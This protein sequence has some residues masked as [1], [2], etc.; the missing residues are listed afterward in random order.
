MPAC[1]VIPWCP[2]CRPTSATPP[3]PEPYPWA[4]R[5]EERAELVGRQ[6]GSSIDP[7]PSLL[8]QVRL[9][10]PIPIASPRVGGR[11]GPFPGASPRV[12]PSNEKADGSKAS[13]PAPAP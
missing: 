3:A 6:L 9:L 8:R 4:A 13:A 10:P 11:D 5:P 12:L 7:A 1:A 2:L